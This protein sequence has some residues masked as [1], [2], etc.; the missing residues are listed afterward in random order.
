MYNIQI[1]YNKRAEIMN[2]KLIFTDV[3]GVLLNWEYAFNE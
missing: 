2:N 1:V 3:D